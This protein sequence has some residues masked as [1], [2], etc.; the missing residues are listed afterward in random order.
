MK[1]LP[2]RGHLVMSGEIFI[3]YNKERGTTGIQWMETTDTANC[4]TMHRITLTNKELI[5]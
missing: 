5:V 2:L 3:Y 4:P 1:I